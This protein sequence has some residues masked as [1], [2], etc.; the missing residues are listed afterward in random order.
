MYLVRAFV[1]FL[2]IYFL[3][4]TKLSFFLKMVYKLWLYTFVE[5]KMRTESETVYTCV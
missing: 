2:T 5:V 4:I 3:L 1:I